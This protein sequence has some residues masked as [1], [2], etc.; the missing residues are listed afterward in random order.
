MTALSP[1]PANSFDRLRECTSARIG[2]GRIGQA[3]PTRPLLEFQLAHARARDAVHTPLDVARLQRVLSLP[4]VV[5]DSAARDRLAYLQDPRLGRTLRPNAPPLVRGDYDL[6]LILADGLSAGAVH[7][8][9][10]ALTEALVK[11]LSTWTIAPVVIARQARVALGDVVGQAL[12]ARAVIVLI[13][14]R[15]G[16]SAADSLSAYLTWAPKA[17]RRDNERNCVS[18]IREAPGLSIDGAAETITRLMQKA[19]RLG[20]TGVDLKDRRLQDQIA[21]PD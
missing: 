14:E 4:T 3:L 6:A 12:G 8:H 2:L 5:V 18:N 1:N 16:L 15:P 7:A 20:F 11:R 19:H 10:A 13:G 17:G 9:A 21:E